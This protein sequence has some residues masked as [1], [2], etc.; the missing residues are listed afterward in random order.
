MKIARKSDPRNDHARARDQKCSPK[1]LETE[2]FAHY[3]SVT[4][5]KL[6]E[7][8]IVAST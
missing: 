8:K 6:G 5:F 7:S 1:T 2:N 4:I 3:Y